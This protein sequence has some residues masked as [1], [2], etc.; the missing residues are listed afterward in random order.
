MADIQ[1]AQLQQRLDDRRITLTVS[2]E[3]TAWL[4]E[5]GFDPIYGARPLRRLVQ[6]AVGDKLAKGILSGEIRDGDDVLVGTLPDGTDLTL[7]TTL[8]PRPTVLP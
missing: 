1:I 5:R 7:A 2:D 6:T 3:A 4:V 8:T